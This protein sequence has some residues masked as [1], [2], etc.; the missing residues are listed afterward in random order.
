M[1]NFL[2][3]VYGLIVGFVLLSPALEAQNSS[4][5]DCNSGTVFNPLYLKS[6]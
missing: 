4:G 2:G 5:A 3:V 6:V 1:K